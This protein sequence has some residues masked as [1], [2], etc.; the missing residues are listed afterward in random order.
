MT[1]TAA[2]R[3]M[4]WR[5]VE[6]EAQVYRRLWYGSV[7]S[8]FLVPVLFLAAMGVGLGGLVDEQQRSVGGVDYLAFVTPGLLAA[9]AMQLAAGNSLWPVMA[10][11]KW[12]RFYHAV[13]A[14]PVSAADVYGG[15]VIWRALREAAAAGAFLIVAALLGGVPSWW[16][17]LALPFAT[18]TATAFTAPLVAFAATQDTDVSFPMIIR[19]VVMPLFLF[20]GTFFPVSQLPGW[21]QPAAVFSPLWHGVELCRDATT[22]D[23]AIG[24][25]VVHVV[26]LAAIIA[27]GWRWGERTF[28]KKLAE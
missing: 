19:L 22:G 15:Y 14:T 7:F 9:M 4:M 17:L 26:V 27:V 28:T 24:P 25:D 20:S 8:S 23:F 6:R 1:V 13:V 16:G 3:S 2:R 21:L 11:T 10:G 5:I 18:L 12:I